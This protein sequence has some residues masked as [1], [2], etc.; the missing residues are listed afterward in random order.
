MVAGETDLCI[1]GGG[2]AGMVAGLLFAR[3]GVRTIV[4]E[5]HS[6]FLR[7]FRGDTVHPSTLRIFSELGLLE[8]LL[9]RP[10]DK[11]HDIGAFIGGKH[12]EIGDF[13]RFDRRWSFIAMMPQWHFLDFVAEEAS[14]YPA[15]TL[16]RDAEATGLEVEEGRVRGVR[17]RRVGE[18]RLI[19]ARL[20]IAADG[21]H[22]VLRGSAGLQV[23]D[24][25]APIDVFWFRVPKPATPENAGSVASWRA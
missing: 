7:D 12:F 18:E 9:E 24:L 8:K 25:G 11:V 15:F 1:V 19:N 6:D 16:V 14:A 17:Y 23:I 4:I 22:S 13:S 10:H 2:P 5:K 3:A 21:R 20:T